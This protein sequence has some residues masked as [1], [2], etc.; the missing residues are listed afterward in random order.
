MLLLLSIR[1]REKQQ[2]QQ[3]LHSP[4]NR[5]F[6]HGSL[7]FV[8]FCSVLVSV[9]MVVAACD[10]YSFFRIRT[11]SRRNAFFLNDQLI[12]FKMFNLISGYW[13]IER[14]LSG[15]LY[16]V[17]HKQSRMKKDTHIHSHTKKPQWDE[18]ILRIRKWLYKEKRTKSIHFVAHCLKIYSICVRF[19]CCFFVLILFSFHC[20]R[21]RFEIWSNRV[22]CPNYVSA[23][24][25]CSHSLIENLVHIYLVNWAEA[26]THGNYDY[27]VAILIFGCGTW[28]S[29]KSF[30][31]WCLMWN[32]LAFSCMNI[33]NI[34]NI[35][36]I[37][38]SADREHS[39]KWFQ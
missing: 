7:R 37:E 24:V 33:S 28:V 3:F 15:S 31:R 17:Y 9:A 35:Y 34:S 18:R 16:V 8:L 32:S 26:R 39:T 12:N 30:F 6:C 25:I 29:L 38:L 11:S 19:R 13:L 27:I 10:F 21:R 4:V 20:D 2:Q 23:E 5:S 36:V 1:K 14:S 22:H